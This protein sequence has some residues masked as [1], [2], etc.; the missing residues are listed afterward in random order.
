[1][2][3]DPAPRHNEPRSDHAPVIATFDF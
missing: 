1:V 2:T 3:N